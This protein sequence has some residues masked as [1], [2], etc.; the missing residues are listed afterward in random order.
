VDGGLRA[1]QAGGR[2]IK[3]WFYA[4]KGV[5]HLS[6]AHPFFKKTEGSFAIAGNFQGIQIFISIKSL[7]FYRNFFD[8][9]I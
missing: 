5:P 9:E 3:I 4:K 2:P 6:V 8:P 7:S 1:G